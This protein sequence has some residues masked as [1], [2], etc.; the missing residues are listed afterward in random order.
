MGQYCKV[1]NE[2]V[3]IKKYAAGGGQWSIEYDGSKYSNFS[4]SVQPPQ[5]GWVVVAHSGA[6]PAPR[7]IYVS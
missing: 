1:D 5:G 4:G 7:L 6:A 2:A 3:T